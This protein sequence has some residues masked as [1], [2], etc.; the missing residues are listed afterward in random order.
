MLGLDM[1]G[2]DLVR[3][4]NKAVDAFFDN[5]LLAAVRL[6][7]TNAKGSFGLCISSSL[8]SDRQVCVYVRVGG[9]RGARI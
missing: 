6:F 9:A 4:V 7:L 1:E 5:D 8:D 3:F 2:G